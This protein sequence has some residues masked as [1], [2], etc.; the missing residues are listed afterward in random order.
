MRLS[1]SA[2]FHP[3]NRDIRVNRVNRVIRVKRN[4]RVIVGVDMDTNMV[5][6]K[7]V[8]ISLCL[9]VLNIT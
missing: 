7:S 2:Q 1:R 3:K 9:H 8:S 5:K 4:N 6:I